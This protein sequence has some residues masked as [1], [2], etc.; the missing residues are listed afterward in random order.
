MCAASVQDRDGAKGALLGLY[1]ISRTYRFIFADARFVGRAADTLHTG[2]EIVRKPTGQRG[3]AVARRRWA[4]ERTLAAWL[5]AYR[6]L[7]R[8][9]EHH[10]AT[11]EAMIRWPAIRLMTCRLARA[12]DAPPPAAGPRPLEYQI[13]RSF[14]NMLLGGVTSTSRTCSLDSK[15]SAFT[16]VRDISSRCG[17]GLSRRFTCRAM[18]VDLPWLRMSE[19]QNPSYTADGEGKSSYL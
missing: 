10:R 11:I 19:S 3:F 5:T 17:H 4:V 12:A 8:D 9:Y 15:S 18:L 2:M 13:T 6:P 1:P 7:A 16:S 14:S